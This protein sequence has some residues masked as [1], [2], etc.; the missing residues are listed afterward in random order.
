MGG[1]SQPI[2]PEGLGLQDW[3]EGVTGPDCISLFLTWKKE[4]NHSQPP[5][6]EGLGLQDWTENS[7]ISTSQGGT[8][9]ALKFRTEE[10]LVEEEGT[11]IQNFKP[12]PYLRG[13]WSRLIIPAWPSTPR[14]FVTK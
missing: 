3:T 11:D 9:E 5:L 2:L 1:H 13:D 6:T 14:I 4:T 12:Y 8:E 10:A 7:C